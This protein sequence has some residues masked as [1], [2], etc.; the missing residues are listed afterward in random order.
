VSPD[1]IALV[2][3]AAA[4]HAGWNFVAKRAGGGIA[5]LWLCCLCEV[6]VL[7]PLAVGYVALETTSLDGEVLAVVVVSGVV[8]TGY[9]AALQRGYATG[10]LS[11]V[12]PITR[13][14]GALLAIAGGVAVLGE[15]PGGLALAGGM[16]LGAAVLALSMQ[17][18]G[19]AGA[20]RSSGP[21]WLAALLV[22]T[23]TLWDKRAVDDLAIAPLVY[24]AGVQACRLAL[25][26]AV[27]ATQRQA[28]RVA[29]TAHRREALAFG[30]L[31]S[32]A[33]LL[34]LVALQS[35]PASIVAPLREVSVLFAA[36]LGARVLDERVGGLRLAAVAAV[37]VGI[38]AIAF[39]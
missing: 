27:A 39:S 35:S 14:G 2:L 21:A 24:L 16:I 15:R 38:A 7:L 32:G 19:G 22:A 6:A 23:Y 4:A 36:A 26:S 20:L 25:L 12:Y 10:D 37:V 5:F 28:V 13:G 30:V 34:V 31:S 18:G 1:A 17:A 11:V 33:Y 8:H 3:L 29:W 9:L